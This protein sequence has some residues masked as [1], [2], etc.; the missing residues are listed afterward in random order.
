[1][2]KKK[3]KQNDTERQKVI[4]VQKKREFMHK[5]EH[6]CS[7]IDEE[8]F[9]LISPSKMECLY[10]SRGSAVGVNTKQFIYKSFYGEKFPEM[11]LESIN[12]SLTERTMPFIEKMPEISFAHYYHVVMPLE[13]CMN[14]MTEELQ[15]RKAC[16]DFLAGMQERIEAYY[17][18]VMFLCASTSIYF[19]EMQH[20]MLK[21][22][23]GLEYR[24]KSEQWKRP[25]ITLTNSKPEKRKFNFKSGEVRSALRMVRLRT[26]DMIHISIK[27]G[28]AH[29]DKGVFEELSLKP[30]VFGIRGSHADTPHPVY[31]LEHAL[32][33]LNE[34][35]G[36][37]SAGLDQYDAAN[38]VLAG[39]YTYSTNGK[40]L[41][42]HRT[43][44]QKS[45]YLL[46]DITDGIILIR[47]FL[48]L[49]HSSTPEGQK[50]KE[51]LGLQKLDINYLAMDRLGTLMN[52]DILKD[53]AVCRI[54]RNAGCGSILEL[55]EDKKDD[56]GIFRRYEK[57]LPLA[58]K[59]KKYLASV[60]AAGDEDADTDDSE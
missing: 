44:G 9:A 24:N 54:F 8:L 48:F 27:D 7:L 32:N 25:V 40:L 60:N 20:S 45:G 5:L 31:V 36:G 56:L 46:A 38:S 12:L 2:A 50:L 59:I 41:I 57:E 39:K 51:Q 42:E 17:N 29:E 37:V 3:G 6:I 53:E 15:G 16:L 13:M 23:V 10:I 1:M 11:I 43:F 22:K 35:T 49:T 34:R 28:E 33:R 4:A 58:D 26:D 47:T 52:S 18:R 21:V 19:S 55:C 30:S 14:T